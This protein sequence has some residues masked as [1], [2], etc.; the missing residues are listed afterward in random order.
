MAFN[1]DLT[2]S[3]NIFVSMAEYEIQTDVSL[4][5]WKN[6]QSSNDILV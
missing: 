3:Q 1:F 2:S 5:P 4:M 6:I